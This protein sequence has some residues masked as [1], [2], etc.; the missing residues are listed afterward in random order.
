MEKINIEQKIGDFFTHMVDNDVRDI[1]I[2]S[3]LEIVKNEKVNSKIAW[4]NTCV[5]M[6]RNGFACVTKGK[7]EVCW[8]NYM[9]KATKKEIE[10]YNKCI[11]SKGFFIG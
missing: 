11:S 9:R 5:R 4:A 8:V 1:F 3:E 10:F 2:L 6:G 7:Q